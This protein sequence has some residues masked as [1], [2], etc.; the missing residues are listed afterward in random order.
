MPRASKRYLSKN[1][2]EDLKDNLSFLI[3]SLNTPSDIEEFFNDFLSDEEK[4]MLSKRL[5][6]HMMLER[7]YRQSDI[8]AV[9]GMSRET[10]RVHQHVWNKG[11]NA[12]KNMMRKIAKREKSKT[13]WKKVESILKPV[14]LA[15]Q[16]KTNMKAR[17]KLLNREYD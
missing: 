2:N 14:E 15:L 4:T 10:I 7:G 16:S 3:S 17:A 12:Y 1:I 5:M 9:L 11:G 6:L 13:F 8:K